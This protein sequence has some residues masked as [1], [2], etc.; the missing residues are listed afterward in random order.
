MM[1]E[2]SA[3]VNADDVKFEQ[4]EFIDGENE[5]AVEF[6]DGED[7]IVV[8]TK[9]DSYA[10]CDF[11]KRRR[12]DPNE[13]LFLR[14][15]IVRF[16]TNYGEPIYDP[17][18]W[19]LCQRH[20]TFPD[21]S[22]YRLWLVNP[23]Y[24]AAFINYW[25]GLPTPTCLYKWFTLW[26][27]AAIVI[28]PVRDLFLVPANIFPSVVFTWEEGNPVFTGYS[29][30]S[31]GAI[32]VDTFANLPVSASG[33]LD[34]IR[35]RFFSFWTQ[36]NIP[37][38]YKW[39]K[40]KY[41][42]SILSI[43]G[44]SVLVYLTV[45]HSIFA[46][47]VDTINSFFTGWLCQR[48]P[49]LIDPRIEAI[50][51][52][53]SLSTAAVLMF[54]SLYKLTIK[55]LDGVFSAQEEHTDD[56]VLKSQINITEYYNY[57]SGEDAGLSE[58]FKQ[59]FK[60]R[61][62]WFTL[63][64]KKQQTK[65]KFFIRATVGCIVIYSL[66]GPAFAS[67]EH[68][69]SLTNFLG[70]YDA[71]S[72]CYADDSDGISISDGLDDPESFFSYLFQH[73]PVQ[74]IFEVFPPWS[75]RSAILAAPVMDTGDLTFLYYAFAYNSIKEYIDSITLANIA[76]Y[77][78]SFSLGKLFTREPMRL[79]KNA[80]HFPMT[81]IA[82][83]VFLLTCLLVPIMTP[84]GA[85]RTVKNYSHL[86]NN[87]VAKAVNFIGCIL[88][89]GFPNALY[90]FSA[91]KKKQQ[92]W[93]THNVL[94]PMSAAYLWQKLGYMLGYVPALQRHIMED[95][96]I[97]GIERRK[98]SLAS[99]RFVR[100]DT[101]EKDMDDI[102]KKSPFSLDYFKDAIARIRAEQAHFNENIH[103]G[104]SLSPEDIIDEL[105]VY[106]LEM[107]MEN[108]RIKKSD[109]DQ[110]YEKAQQQYGDYL[111]GTCWS[112]WLHDNAH[113]VFSLMLIEELQ[114]LSSEPMN[115]TDQNEEVEYSANVS[116]LDENQINQ[117]DQPA[118]GWCSSA[119]TA[120]YSL[121]GAVGN[122]LYSCYQSMNCCGGENAM[123][124]CFPSCV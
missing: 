55:R 48:I 118:I 22:D 110:A 67:L 63:D 76:S 54:N 26:N 88:A 38:Q 52:V 111:G 80:D 92:S 58:N 106:W 107:N 70:S 103:K 86:I 74:Y 95:I 85:M 73:S 32:G 18:K 109:L 81:R 23:A 94:R 4:V 9:S 47:A 124:D 61:G 14:S 121:F 71:S 30:L 57:G 12:L 46:M 11:D 56:T 101:V 51:T 78:R 29:I 16:I 114:K 44:S 115:E 119:L 53:A 83:G 102:F 33:M 120:T 27:A 17:E 31:N 7:G 10:S 84:Y 72:Y 40:R 19:Y 105:F 15:A 97:P 77:Y 116:L 62:V 20:L 35:D 66:L 79:P 36:K 104:K 117:S 49:N 28:V 42:L 13:K 8:E 39:G 6:G 5:I 93:F 82:I 112:C 59:D 2:K 50:L 37:E 65:I 64:S 3:D 122:G 123:D 24:L 75:T 99:E 60:K 89:A 90:T 45:K 69:D 1:T 91:V 25:A 113:Y 98:T 87:S 43:G 108:R 96:L 41:C 34:V 100:T 21:K 68:E